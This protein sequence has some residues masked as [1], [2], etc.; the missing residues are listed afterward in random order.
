MSEKYGRVNFTTIYK[1]KNQLR[2]AIHE[3]DVERTRE[4]WDKLEQWI[5]SPPMTPTRRD[6][7]LPDVTPYFLILSVVVSLLW[8]GIDRI[9]TFY[10]YLRRG[11]G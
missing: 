6:H 8:N 4:L 11:R 3:E 2:E 5:D 1:L 7:D 10:A 9:Q